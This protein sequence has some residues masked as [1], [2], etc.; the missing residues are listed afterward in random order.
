MRGQ[1]WTPVVR[2][3][4][5]LY[6][7]LTINKLSHL[8]DLSTNDVLSKM[9]H[10]KKITYITRRSEVVKR[11]DDDY[12]DTTLDLDFYID[13]EVITIADTRVTRNVSDYFLKNSLKF[14]ALCVKAKAINL[15]GKSVISRRNPDKKG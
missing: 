8:M 3:Y 13:D 7:T 12:E 6:N 5:K 1:V 4:L 10:F 14:K 11:N 9:L 15:N 2:S